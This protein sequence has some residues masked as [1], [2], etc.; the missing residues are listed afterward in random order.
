[1]DREGAT[2]PSSTLLSLTGYLDL[3][4][5]TWRGRQ[6]K[7]YWFWFDEQTCQLK[8]YR[9]QEA[10]QHGVF[11]PL[12]TVD[13]RYAAVTPPMAGEELLAN[14][15]Q[16][17]TGGQTYILAAPDAE[18]AHS[19][20]KKLQEK[21]E[22][23]IRRQ[24]AQGQTDLD[25]QAKKKIL[26][27]NSRPGVLLSSSEE[28]KGQDKEQ[29][30]TVRKILQR[31]IKL[32]NRHSSPLESA[33]SYPS[34]VIPS[35]TAI[36]DASSADG[37]EGPERREV[38]EL[39]HAFHASQEEVTRQQ[40][41]VLLLKDRMEKKNEKIVQ[42][43]SDID[44]LRESLAKIKSGKSPDNYE[45]EIESLQDIIGQYKRSVQ[46]LVDEVE[47]KRLQE[48]EY[49]RR[50]NAE[51]VKVQELERE[52]NKF[53]A[54]FV[55]LLSDKFKVLVPTGPEEERKE[56][57]DE[58][59]YQDELLQ[60]LQRE[61]D[62]NVM[63][64]YKS[65][66][67]DEYGDWHDWHSD[68]TVQHYL[69]R[70]LYLHYT[71]P[72]V[73]ML[74][75]EWADFLKPIKHMKGKTYLDLLPGNERIK[76]RELRNLLRRGVPIQYRTRIWSSLVYRLVG[77]VKEVKD[78]AVGAENTYYTSLLLSKADTTSEKQILLD[79]HRT[80]PS[81]AHF[82]SKG[83]GAQ[84]L[85]NVLL[86]Y[87]RHNKNIGYCQGMNLIAA[88]GLL[89]LDEEAT[90]WFLYVV[91]E[92]LLPLDY[93]SPGLFGAQADQAVLRELLPQK[94]P[95][96]SAHLDLHSIDVT[97][98]TFNWFLTL[99]IDAMPTESALRILDC[100]LMEGT[101][102]LFRVGLGVLKVNARHLLS[103]T[104]PVA[105]FQTLKEIAKHTF[106]IDQ[107]LQVAFT[108]IEPFP[109]RNVLTARHS[110]HYSK[111]KEQ[112]LLREKELKEREV[113]S[114]LEKLQKKPPLRSLLLERSFRE[115]QKARRHLV[116]ECGCV[117]QTGDEEPDEE[118][119]LCCGDR[120]QGRIAIISNINGRWQTT[121]PSYNVSS[122]VISACYVRSDLVVLGTLDF[123]VYVF[124]CKS[125]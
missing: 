4:Q 30:S 114:K 32:E 118:V 73:E 67:K 19:W 121:V 13:L 41:E 47:L 21:R 104:D 100:F 99:F 90:F 94:L 22:Q 50:V 26:Q 69:C 93:F 49:E 31:H 24:S 71:Q 62:G 38:L 113:R 37:L 115:T 89:F 81:N 44:D 29:S 123:N 98:I 91:I 61:S 15:F 110:Y 125:E 53:K 65:S 43:N 39:R 85:K 75:Q 20:I 87:S 28:S 48:E 35:N 101:K 70:Q 52:V 55:T 119:W 40:K 95:R 7:R 5:K 10:Y 9:S 12:M 18:K 102:V 79:L 2:L 78:N 122:R 80:L 66:F 58:P 82:R 111:I 3:Y 108:G 25:R 34:S 74:V 59:L 77:K 60:L 116:W 16:I 120:H 107:L 88:I 57:K 17:N 92:K 84:K 46:S 54:K 45:L 124:H 76:R 68:T 106:N 97:L 8:Y 6:K 103:I 11:D 56:D 1:M 36:S 42:L 112:W 83:Y 105:L 117:R 63:F 27:P 33:G 109:S 64:Q 86:A 96:L 23:W 72:E 51:R 14:Q